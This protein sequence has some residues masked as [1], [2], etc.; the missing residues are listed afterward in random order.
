I[1]YFVRA[2]SKSQRADSRIGFGEAEIRGHAPAA[3]S[4]DRIVDDLEGD[5]RS[6]DLDHCDFKAC[7]L[8]ADFVHH[9]GRLE[10]EQSRHFNIDARRGGA[11]PPRRWIGN[12]LAKG[13]AQLQ[14]P[15]HLLE[16]S[17]RDP[18]RAH[19]MMDAPGSQSSLGNFKAAALAQ[20][21]VGVRDADIV[22]NDL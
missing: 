18:N 8:V 21:Q 10:A 15:Y 20:D 22:K 14:P 12:A 6:C 9:I 19:A 1:V 3:V 7:R 5:P 4:L 11:L 13:N 17:F 2:I 16:G